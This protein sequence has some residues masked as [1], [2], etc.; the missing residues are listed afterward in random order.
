[1]TK[2]AAPSQ[3]R[4]RR[5]DRDS[6]RLG[7]DSEQ[8]RA[9]RELDPGSASGTTVRAAVRHLRLGLDP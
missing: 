7:A 5:G 4:N 6:L 9:N 1:M 8:A 2:A 3:G